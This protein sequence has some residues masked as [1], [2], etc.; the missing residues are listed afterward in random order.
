MFCLHGQQFRSDSIA[1]KTTV[2]EREAQV[3]VFSPY[4]TLK[5]RQKARVSEAENVQLY[6]KNTRQ[7]T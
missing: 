1:P 7:N 4:S 2:H 3:Q 6:H 5:G